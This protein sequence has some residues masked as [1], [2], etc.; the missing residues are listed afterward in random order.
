M[1]PINSETSVANSAFMHA[2]LRK[3]LMLAYYFPPMGL[4]GVQRTA[5]FVKY[6][7]EFGWKPIVLTINPT[8][9]FAYDD[10]LL[11]E[12][13]HPA[14]E[15]VRTDTKDI[16]K[17]ASAATGKRQ[18]KMPS[19]QT[20]RFLSALSQ[21]VF[22]PD[23]KIG[24]KKFAIEKASEIIERE[25]DIDVIYST[26]PPFSSHLIALELRAKY[27]LPAV[28][29]FRD[30]WVENAAHLYC[31]PFHRRKH[32]A[33]EEYVLTH[34]DRIITANRALKELFLRK[35]L[36]QL[37]HKDISIIWHGYD[38]DDFRQVQPDSRTRRKLRFVYSGRFF[39]SSPAPFF[40]GL[41]AAIVQEPA[42]RESVELCFVGLF[43][44]EHMSLAEKLGLKDMIEVHGYRP[45]LEAIA[46][47]LRGDVLWATLNPV[48]GTEVITHG[49]L[50]EYI[51]A[52]KTLFG[53]VPEGAAHQLILEANGVVAHP[54]KTQD[55]A[56]KILE[57]Y[58]LWKRNMLPTPTEDFVQR[59]ERRQLT[60]QLAKEFGQLIRIE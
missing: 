54:K 37:Q 25:K 53:I 2:P 11:A 13:S 19:E 8:A 6:L 29:D 57:L 28:L 55:I 46:E 24:W 60:A 3:V 40:R 1:T 58:A 34:A 59:F 56:Q 36:G 48:K 33:L 16:T 47:L 27:H 23:N 45:H 20:R 42:L 4:S 41:K 9:Y 50:F 10:S 22:I 18:F 7:P 32:E 5:K 17:A 39:L 30:P 21:L 14:I 51:G 12:L 49:K 26:A 38:A 43:E 15:I 35:Y 52:R 44:K 31:T